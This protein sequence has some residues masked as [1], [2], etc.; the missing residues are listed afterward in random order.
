MVPS[1]RPRAGG[2]QRRSGARDPS[3]DPRGTRNDV[4]DLKG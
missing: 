2:L 3:I 1:R 4:D